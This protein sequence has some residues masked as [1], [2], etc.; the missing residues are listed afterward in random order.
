M[1]V[2]QLLSKFFFNFQKKNTYGFSIDI[3]RFKAILVEIERRTKVLWRK[4]FGQTDKQID[5]WNL[6]V[7]NFDIDL[8]YNSSKHFPL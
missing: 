4:N 6:T 3:L 2:P 5:K 7:A 1:F 8:P